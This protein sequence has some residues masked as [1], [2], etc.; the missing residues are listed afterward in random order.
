MKKLFFLALIVA[1]L[2]GP[3]CAQESSFPIM[4]DSQS[5]D[6]DIGDSIVRMRE[7][8]WDELSNAQQQSIMRY[9]NSD[10]DDLN[11]QQRELIGNKMQLR[12]NGMSDVERQ[13][14][15]ESTKGDDQQ[16]PESRFL[17]PQPPA[18]DYVPATPGEKSSGHNMTPGGKSAG[19]SMTPGRSGVGG[20]M[21]AGEGGVGGGRYTTGTKASGGNSG[22]SR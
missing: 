2:S 12:W 6:S 1:A 19:G 22:R 7:K 9:R 20:N 16:K 4:M 18:S 13:A 15:L 21:S 14:I 11:P 10:W 8:N 3:V 5:P 17:T